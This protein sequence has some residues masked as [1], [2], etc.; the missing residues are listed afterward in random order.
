MNIMSFCTPPPQVVWHVKIVKKRKKKEGKNKTKQ[1]NKLRDKRYS[2]KH[3]TTACNPPR[4]I[5]ETMN[6]LR[7]TKDERTLWLFQLGLHQLLVSLPSLH[8][9]ERTVPSSMP[10]LQLLNASWQNMWKR[11]HV[12]A[13]RTLIQSQSMTEQ[14]TKVIYSVSGRAMTKT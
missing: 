4:E 3:K 8:V 12:K 11:T 2:R 7:Q 14:E 6:S 1:T 5:K 9:S 10:D 13:G